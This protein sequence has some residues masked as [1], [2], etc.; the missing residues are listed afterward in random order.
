MGIKN[1]ANA[2]SVAAKCLTAAALTFVVAAAAIAADAAVIFKEKGDLRL[3]NRQSREFAFAGT[4]AAKGRVVVDF[5]NRIDYPRAAGWCPCWQIFVNGT[6]LSAAA[7]F[8]SVYVDLHGQASGA[9]V[10]ILDRLEDVSVLLQNCGQIIVVVDH[11]GAF[12][13]QEVLIGRQKLLEHPVV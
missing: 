4:D 5:N 2:V 3:G 8:R 11:I 10:L 12:V 13:F 7:F 1:T 9:H 6:P